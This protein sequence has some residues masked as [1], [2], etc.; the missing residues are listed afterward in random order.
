MGV[1]NPCLT[2]PLHAQFLITWISNL[3][4][5]IYNNPRL[6]KNK[7]LHTATP[8]TLLSMCKCCYPHRPWLPER[9][10]LFIEYVPWIV[11]L[12]CFQHLIFPVE[13]N[14][15]SS[16]FDVIPSARLALGM[17]FSPLKF[18]FVLIMN[19]LYMYICL[20]IIDQSNNIFWHSGISIQNLL[21][22][23]SV[24]CISIFSG[25]YFKSRN[26]LY[27][28]CLPEWGIIALTHVWDVMII[29]RL[30]CALSIF[31]YVCNILTSTSS[32]LGSPLLPNLQFVD[33]GNSVW[34]GESKWNL[35]PP[36]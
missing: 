28:I 25:L 6:Y 24:I 2:S 17:H 20:Y 14:L 15:L 3:C 18:H 7:H 30:S 33:K 26:W 4:F 23:K 5:R 13:I 12:F 19:L 27:V 9:F 22:S 10:V 34:G 36:L 16:G 11:F 1:G 29:Y 8:A 31:N 32:S 21:H 35:Y